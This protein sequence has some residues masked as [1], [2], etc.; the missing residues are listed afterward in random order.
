MG[1]I[2]NVKWPPNYEME[3]VGRYKLY[4]HKCQLWFGDSRCL[5]RSPL[6]N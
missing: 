4:C 6:L 2:L 3:G 5:E 1:Q